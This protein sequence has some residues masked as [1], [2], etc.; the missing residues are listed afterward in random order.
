MVLTNPGTIEGRQAVHSMGMYYCIKILML[1]V[2]SR[3]SEY[4]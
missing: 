2:D 4:E 1:E 3:A